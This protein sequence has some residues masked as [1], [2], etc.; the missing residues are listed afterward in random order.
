MDTEKIWIQKKNKIVKKVNNNRKV[1]IKTK[2]WKGK[3]NGNRKKKLT[4]KKNR[5]RNMWIQ[6]KN[7][8]RN[9]N[10]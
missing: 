3:K 8:N 6:K 5:N 2:M 10:M 4:Q 1:E 7:R 9:K